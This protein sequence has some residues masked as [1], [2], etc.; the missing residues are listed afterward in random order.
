[1]AGSS[2]EVDARAKDPMTQNQRK[3]HLALWLILGPLLLILVVLAIARRP[4]TT[5]RPHTSA[6]V[7][8]K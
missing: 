3:L 4:D 1:V 2:P 7:V 6:G 8:N 5:S